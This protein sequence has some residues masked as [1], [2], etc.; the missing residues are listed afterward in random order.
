MDEDPT[1]QMYTFVAKLGTKNNRV[2]M[3]HFIHADNY[4]VF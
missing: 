3:I 2:F 1:D 4:A